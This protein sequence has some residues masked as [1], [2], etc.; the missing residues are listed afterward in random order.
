MDT[1]NKGHSSSKSLCI[2]TV[3]GQ[4]TKMNFIGLIPLVRVICLVLTPLIILNI[5]TAAQG[6]SRMRAPPQFTTFWLRVLLLTINFF[7]LPI[8]SLFPSPV[9]MSNLENIQLPWNVLWKKI[10]LYKL[11][12]F[13]IPELMRGLACSYSTYL[14]SLFL[15]SYLYSQITLMSYQ[16]EDK[17][18]L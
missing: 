10:I 8:L 9:L 4:I 13:W 12:S 16:R 2:Q 14:Q 3:P 15:S 1:W 11:F 18:D 5:S 7:I 17:I 6:H